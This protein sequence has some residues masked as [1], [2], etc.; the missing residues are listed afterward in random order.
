[1]TEQGKDEF[2]D[3]FVDG[4]ATI[5]ERHPTAE[6]W[7]VL[8]SVGVG[9]SVGERLARGGRAWLNLRFTTS[10]RI[11]ERVA[12]LGL[13]VSPGRENHPFGGRYSS[14]EREARWSMALGSSAASR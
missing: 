8:P 6:K 14:G 12:G 5:C 9:L 10:A 2:M 11:A 13:S 3:P 7:V 1:V 4:L